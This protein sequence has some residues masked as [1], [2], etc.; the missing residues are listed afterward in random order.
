MRQK[1]VLQAQRRPGQ[2]LPEAQQ[3]PL[4]RTEARMLCMCAWTLAPWRYWHGL[5]SAVHCSSLFHSQDRIR[6][7]SPSVR[8][9]AVGAE[10]VRS[11][12][13]AAIT[14]AVRVLVFGRMCLP[15]YPLTLV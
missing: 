12:P 15:V 2:W 5:L 1:S 11:H 7:L 13:C 10:L 4:Q 6:L 3:R 14:Q 8:P 9:Q